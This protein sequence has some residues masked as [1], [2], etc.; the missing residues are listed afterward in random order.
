MDII[1]TQIEL[2]QGIIERD[3]DCID[4][5]WCV[6]CP[7]AE[8]CVLNAVTKARL[9]PKEERVRRA[10]DKLFTYELEKQLDDEEA[11]DIEVR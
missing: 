3:G 6:I 4:A 2:L 8:K 1:E 5:S 10:V 9:L 7:F 11:N